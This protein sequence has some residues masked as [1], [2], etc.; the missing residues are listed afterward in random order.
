MDIAETVRKEI[1][2]ANR[3]GLTRY[4]IV[5]DLNGQ[6][7]ETQLSRLMNEKTLTAE[8]LGALLDYFGYKLVKGKVRR[9]TY[10]KR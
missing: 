10:G 8:T 3:K 4:Q 9:N 5:Q 6:V 7:S 1:E 2:Q